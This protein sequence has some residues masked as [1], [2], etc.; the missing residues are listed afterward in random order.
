MIETLSCR[1]AAALLALGVAGFPAAAAP[2]PRV[3][4]ASETLHGP[5]KNM[6]YHPVWQYT[7]DRRT[8]YGGTPH[9]PHPRGDP[10]SPGPAVPPAR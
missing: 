5:E 3:V 7:T 8:P 4:E 6:P 9:T 10:G 2:A 1:F